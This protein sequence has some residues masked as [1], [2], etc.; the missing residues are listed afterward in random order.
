MALVEI[1]IMIEEQRIAEFYSMYGVW[2]GGDAATKGSVGGANVASS[3]QLLPWADSEEDLGLAQD[4]WAKLPERAKSMFGLLLDSPGKK[5][6]AAAI[7]SSLEIPHG[8][9]GVAGVLAW[10]GRYSA[11]MGKQLPVQKEDGELGKGANYWIEEDIAELF[12]KA[13]SVA[14]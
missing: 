5:V 11:G 4:L 14:K 13:R 8:I 3:L 9:S 6:S 2:M 10:P 12:N 7:G 1:K